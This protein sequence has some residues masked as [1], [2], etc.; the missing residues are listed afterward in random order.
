MIP[1]TTVTRNATQDGLT[2]E[3]YRDIYRELRQ[4]DEQAQKFAISL[5]KFIKLIDS[6]YSKALWNQYDRG[7][8]ELN[9]EQCNELRRAVGLTALPPTVSEAIAA[10]DP[11]AEVTK[12]GSNSVPNRI[13]LLANCEPV[14]LHINGGIRA[15]PPAPHVT[16]I[17]R[18]T[19]SARRLIRPVASIEQN[20]RR[21]ALLASW[22][23]I[24]NAGLKVL[25]DNN[26]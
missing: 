3:D 11:N 9:R 15:E 2:A 18:P 6:Q 16:A 17:T 10:A 12:V 21:M 22:T 19:R 14:T 23:E 5:D 26:G 4:F 1:V 20:E 8:K 25:E 13:I 24:I 7:E